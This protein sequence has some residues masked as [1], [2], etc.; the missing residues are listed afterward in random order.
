MLGGLLI[1]IIVAIVA[2]ILDA[3]SNGCIQRNAEVAIVVFF[4]HFIFVFA[5]LGWLLDDFAALVV[6]VSLPLIVHLHWKAS[7]TC[8]VDD[9]TSQLCGERQQFHHLSWRF[10]LSH[11]V[12]S[13][14][15]G[16]GWFIAVYKLY[17]LLR[18]EYV[19]Q[20]RRSSASSRSSTSYR[21]SS[22]TL[23]A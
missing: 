1:I 5:L 19:Q 8:V 23:V 2:F 17:R 18:K 14:V 21:R 20:R 4:H 6:Y 12:T 3:M 15:V 11:T 22:L 10:G 13:V 7:T 9:V 16:I